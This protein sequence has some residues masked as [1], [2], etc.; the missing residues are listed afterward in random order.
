MDAD[1]ISKISIFAIPVLM[2]IA[3]HEAAHAWAARYFGDNTVEIQH[4]I[5]LNPIP[6]IDPVGTILLPLMLV[7]GGSPIIFGWAKPVMV[8]G[9]AFKNP[10]HAWRWVAAAGPVANLIMKILWVIVLKM[11]LS[12]GESANFLI[13]V[14]KA[15][16]IINLV[17]AVFN[18]LPILP[19]DGGRILSTLLPT[20]WAY[21][22]AT[23]ERYGMIIVLVLSLTGVLATIMR[24]IQM[25]LL[26][27][28]NAWFF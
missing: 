3:M 17:L 16:V 2:A 20:K 27:F 12:L 18:L 21:H 6:H 13:Q 24:P 28:L 1:L 4:R 8:S 5:T 10:R 14:A 11:S 15:G 7:L 25:F 19:L 22:Y 26:D 9:R 23:T